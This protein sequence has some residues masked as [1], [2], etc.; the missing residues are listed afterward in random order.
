M[1]PAMKTYK[2][3]FSVGIAVVMASG[4]SFAAATA[5]S[6]IDVGA[7]YHIRHSE[8]AELPFADGDLTYAAG[9][10]VRDENG[11]LQLLCGFTPEFADRDDLDYG[12]TPEANLLFTDGLFQGGL[13]ILS[14]YTKNS[15]GNDDWM[16][17]Y[18]QWVLGLNVP[19]GKR[20]SLQANAYYVFET[21]SRLNKFA[22]D[23]VEFGGF[24]TYKF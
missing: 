3:L 20:L 24:I 14:T 13:G 22:F 16:D 7:R 10:E 4:L 1:M 23:D 15:G 11:L 21:W 12:I 19:L 8:F 6:G 9:Y 17:L 18:W 5:S 2:L